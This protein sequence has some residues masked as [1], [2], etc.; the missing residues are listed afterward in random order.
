MARTAA[1]WINPMG[2]IMEL[3]VTTHVQQVINNPNRFGLTK[4][5]IEKTFDDFGERL[6]SESKARDKIFLSLFKKGFIRIRL[7]TNKY[8][9]VSLSG[10]NSKSKKVLQ[11]WASIAKKQVGAGPHMPVRIV[12]FN[13]TGVID[14]Y[15]VNDIAS[16][17]HL[18]ESEELE[19]FHFHP[20]FV[21][22]LPVW[23][24]TLY[25]VLT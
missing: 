9:S 12:D 10:W 23:K 21:N 7:Y 13:R 14:D 8:W 4:Q 3:P 11:K 5:S 6:G 25:G 24:N 18:Y 19:M 15:T 2:K 1:Y 20:E 17:K 22:E 16:S